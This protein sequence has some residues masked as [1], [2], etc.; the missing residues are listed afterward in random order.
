MKIAARLILPLILAA[1]PLAAA[2]GDEAAVRDAIGRQVAAWNARD[3]AAYASLLAEDVV[4]VTDT[5]KML[6]GRDAAVAELGADA[7][8]VRIGDMSVSFPTEDLA[9]AH[10]RYAVPPVEVAETQLLR[11]APSGWIAVSQQMT[12]VQAAGAPVAVA[13][14]PAA[15]AKPKRCILATK[16]GDCWLSGKSK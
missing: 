5:G 16:S 4:L 7:P 1:T 6:R 12:V 11:R 13:A 9:L 3:G 2:P 15:P 14:P 10:V 8:Q